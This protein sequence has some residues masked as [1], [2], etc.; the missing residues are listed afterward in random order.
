MDSRSRL[1]HHGRSVPLAPKLAG[2]A[3]SASNARC[4]VKTDDVQRVVRLEGVPIAAHR[5]Q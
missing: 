4:L 1:N 2:N 3:T 5:K